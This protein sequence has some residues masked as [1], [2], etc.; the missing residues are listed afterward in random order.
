VAVMEAGPRCHVLQDEHLGQ[1]LRWAF[2]LC[3]LILP[4]L[5]THR[6]DM[7]TVTICRSFLLIFT[8]IISVMAFPRGSACMRLE[9]WSICTRLTR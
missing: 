5:C 8:T 7:V 2:M 1:E 6:T 3:E 9:R 4:E